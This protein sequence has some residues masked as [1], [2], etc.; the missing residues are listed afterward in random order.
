MDYSRR[1]VVQ[2]R[3]QLNSY[4]DKIVR[5]VLLLGL[6]LVLAAIVAVF[7]CLAAGGIGL[8]KSILAGTPVGSTIVAV[9]VLGFG[10]CWVI[11]KLK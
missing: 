3:R 10:I 11:G 2:R 4:G 8:F 1:G 6:K 5:K 9:D 7:I